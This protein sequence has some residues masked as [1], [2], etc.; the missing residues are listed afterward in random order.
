M[1][2]QLPTPDA[3]VEPVPPSPPEPATNDQHAHGNLLWGTVLGVISSLAYTG[4]NV[5]LRQLAVTSDPAWTSCIKA[6]PTAVAAWGMIA[7]R[8]KRGKPALPPARLVPM[9]VLTGVFMQVGGNVSF[10]FALSVL[11]LAVTIPILFGMLIVGGA[12]C[13]RI[14]LGEGISSKALVSM[15]LL[16]A[17]VTILSLGA[18]RDP[19][20]KISARPKVTT[21]AEAL[22]ESSTELDARQ[23]AT[24]IGAAILCGF[25]YA[26]C[27]VMIR[28]TSQIST[29]GQQV[30]LSATLMIL[31]CCGVVS[32]GLISF[33]R[34]GTDGM[35]ATTS[36]EFTSM[37]A[38]GVLNAVAFFA[39]GRALEMI[40]IVEVNALNASQVAMAALVGVLFFSEPPTFTLV[41][42]VTLTIV[43]LLI[44][45]RRKK[46]RGE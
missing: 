33:F 13:G 25:A 21:M 43:G 30:P 20:Q 37:L 38:A 15:G 10:Q 14:L 6:I 7:W 36:G 34:I 3:A 45:D 32:L 31:S 5:F 8:A 17:A 29:S 28:R 42:G 40:P 23:L 27:N 44:V 18:G 41:L 26:L 11:G 4:A 46:P 16:L 9:L 24:G 19:P 12:L 39:L 1:N 35:F 22:A 2:H